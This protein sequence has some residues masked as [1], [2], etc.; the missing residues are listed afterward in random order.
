M[1]MKR[2]LSLVCAATLCLSLAACGNADSSGS[3]ASN[4]DGSGSSTSQGTATDFPNKTMTI[5]CPY[6]AGGGTDL[7]L[8]MPSLPTT[9]EVQNL[10]NQ[11][12][13]KNFDLSMLNILQ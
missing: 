2:F 8:R 11:Q 1:S 10:M 7:A 4:S 12:H 5:I 6:G 13:F 9:Q 3:S